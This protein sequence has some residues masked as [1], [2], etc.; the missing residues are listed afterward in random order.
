MAASKD[1]RGLPLTSEDRP[2]NFM[3]DC[4]L[5]LVIKTLLECIDKE[6]STDETIVWSKERLTRAE[7]LKILP[8]YDEKP[9]E[10][11][12]RYVDESDEDFSNDILLDILQAPTEILELPL[13]IRSYGGQKPLVMIMRMT[14]PGN[15]NTSAG[16]VIAN[17]EIT[18]KEIV[19]KVFRLTKGEPIS[20]LRFYKNADGVNLHIFL[21][22]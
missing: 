1:I 6:A 3:L 2:I 16:F 8:R 10:G 13:T 21:S 9:E 18:I 14:D 5:R 12:H 17:E 7:Y 20:T 11:E 15:V 19:E 4:D 22:C